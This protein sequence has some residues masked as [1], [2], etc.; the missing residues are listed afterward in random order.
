MEEARS[1]LR[2]S[3]PR[4]PSGCQDFFRG[5]GEDGGCLR[6]RKGR[7]TGTTVSGNRGRGCG[8]MRGDA[9]RCLSNDRRSSSTRRIL[10]QREQGDS[11]AGQQE[12]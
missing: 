11:G 12:S 7:S 1:W 2:P 8:A 10:P 3:W 6:G 4:T 5:R 9:I